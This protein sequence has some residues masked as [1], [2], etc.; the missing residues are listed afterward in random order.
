MSTYL[1]TGVA[2]FIGSHLVN[3]L[4]TM[5]H[6]V[7]GLD[8]FSSGFRENL[9]SHPLFRFIEGD[10]R[11][12]ETCQAVCKGVD[13]ILHQA[14]LGSVPRSIEE[15]LLYH[16]NNVT[17]TLNLLLAAR[18]AGV[19]RFVLASSSSVYGDTPILPKIETMPLQPKSPYAISKLAC[20]H[21]GKLFNDIYELPTIGLRYFNVFGPRQNP[22]SQYA[23]VI[24]KFLK[25]FLSNES[26]TIFGDGEQTRDFTFIDNVIDANLKACVAPLSSCGASYNIGCGD[27]ISLNQLVIEIQTLT[28]ST[29]KPIYADTRLG[30]VRD[31]LAS[32]QLATECLNLAPQISLRDG[33]NQT[34]HWYRS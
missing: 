5:G 18:D 2:G 6:E 4:V 21:Y 15:P 16:H 14:A 10:I 23:A 32:I 29:A 3:R 20:E 31:S 30:D 27:R 33:L 28:G 22:D 17:G 25:A 34:S 26:P 1:I 9:I 8:N 19:K 24:P 11:D 7:V 12:L 13:F